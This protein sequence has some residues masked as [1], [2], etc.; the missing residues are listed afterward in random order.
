MTKADFTNSPGKHQSRQENLAFV[1]KHLCYMVGGIL[2]G[3]W[4]EMCGT[5]DETF[6]LL[7]TAGVLQPGVGKYIGVS[8]VLENVARNREKFAADI[9]AGIADWIYGEWDHVLYSLGQ[10]PDQ[11]PVVVNFDPYNGPGCPLTQLTKGTLQQ[12]RKFARMKGYC[13]L[14]MYFCLRGIGQESPL[15]DPALREY[16]DFLHGEFG[17][18][19]PV[20]K[21]SSSRGPMAVMRV[22]V[23]GSHDPR[24]SL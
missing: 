10:D 15:D 22:T 23:A 19:P 17:F 20:G 4:V 8:N 24:T 14:L 13:I 5:P 21:Y 3:T 9:Q 1:E 11:V 16:M 12:V 7:K 6:T 18:R 2:R